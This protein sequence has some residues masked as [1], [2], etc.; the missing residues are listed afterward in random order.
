MLSGGQAVVEAGE[1]ASE[2]V[3]VGGGVR[4]PAVL[5]RSQWVW[6]W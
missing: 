6:P 3:A 5:R 2:E 1:E 4:P